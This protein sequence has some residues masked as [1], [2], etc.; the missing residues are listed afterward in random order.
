MQAFTE[1][2]KTSVL[3]VIEYEYWYEAYNG[4]GVGVSNA[5]SAIKSPANALKDAVSEFKGFV[6]DEQV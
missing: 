6:A 5:I 1:M 2:A 3:G 4:M